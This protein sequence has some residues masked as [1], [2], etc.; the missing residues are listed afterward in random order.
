MIRQRFLEDVRFWLRQGRVIYICDAI[1]LTAYYHADDVPAAF[2]VDMRAT[3]RA[4]LRHAF[5]HATLESYVISVHR[6]IL[7]PEQALQCRLAW[8]D[9]LILEAANE[10]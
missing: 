8:L 1:A 5:P 6:H 4:G 9:K 7:T 10:A 3:I 2:V